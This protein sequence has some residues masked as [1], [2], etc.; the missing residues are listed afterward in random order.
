M[1][2][3]ADVWTRYWSGIAARAGGGCLPNSAGPVEAAQQQVWQSFARRLPRSAR[4][5]DLATG[6]GVVLG[7]IAAVRPD[8]KP[9]GVDS[10]A[11]LPPPPKGVV[12]KPGV[13]LERLPFADARFNAATSQ[14]GFEYAEAEPAAAELARVLRPGAELLMIVHHRDSAIVAHNASRAEALRWAIGPEFLLAKA[15]AFAAAGAGFSV[16]ALFRA[17]PA[18]ASR[19][20]PGQ[21]AAAEFAIGLVQRLE[22][23]RSRPP[24]EAQALIRAI[25]EEAL[26]EIARV[27]LLQRAA[28][29]QAGARAIAA[30]L[31]A[32]GI[33]MKAPAVLRDPH[34]G[35]PLAWLLS[36]TR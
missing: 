5:L 33:A 3:S 23:G 25:E 36:G 18:E 13:P 1:K 35:G 30:E 29:D 11:A 21:S 14:F 6:N 22:A 32:A 17:A 27:E 15:K 8:L 24:A 19:R 2:G 4:L 20:F 7:W 28:R 31:T 16:P 34:G 12:L 26:G 9:V 10:A